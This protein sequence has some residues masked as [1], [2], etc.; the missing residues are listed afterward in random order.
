M[1]GYRLRADYEP[2]PQ[3]HVPLVAS[4]ERR[5]L[6][7]VGASYGE[8][9]QTSHIQQMQLSVKQESNT[10]TRLKMNACTK[11]MAYEVGE[12]N[13]KH[14]AESPDTPTNCFRG[15]PLSDIF[16]SYRVHA[17]LVLLP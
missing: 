1:P 9:N 3:L 17:K 15:T 8:V 5:P 16:G 13:P 10:A 11:F 7:P 2:N 12:N 14:A 6:S 4:H